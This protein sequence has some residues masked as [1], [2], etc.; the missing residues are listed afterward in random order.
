MAAA[1]PPPVLDQALPTLHDSPSHTDLQPESQGSQPVPFPRQSNADAR[2][3]G[4]PGSGSKQTIESHSAPGSGA[5][6]SPPRSA[7]SPAA[8]IGHTVEGSHPGPGHSSAPLADPRYLNPN[9]ILPP[10]VSHPRRIKDDDL[11]PLPTPD[12]EASSS[13]P[14]LFRRI[15]KRLRPAVGPG[16]QSDAP[17][18]FQI[19]LPTRSRSRSRSRARGDSASGADAPQPQIG[20]QRRPHVRIPVPIPK[21]PAPAP[22]PNSFTSAENRRAALRA[23]GLVPASGSAPRYRDAHGYWMPLSEQE[24]ELDRMFAVVVEEKMPSPDHED[25]E[26]KKF[27]DAW[28]AKYRSESEQ[29]NGSEEQATTAASPSSD[30]R[31]GARAVYEDGSRSALPSATDLAHASAAPAEP[32]RHARRPSADGAMRGRAYSAS[33]TAENRRPVLMPVVD[34]SLPEMPFEDTAAHRLPRARDRRSSDVSERVSRWFQTSLRPRS[35]SASRPASAGADGGRAVRPV[36]APPL[37]RRV[38]R[39]DAVHQGE[40]RET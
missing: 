10:P 6:S 31:H 26:A 29:G 27:R 21:A 23:R 18:S 34:P 13:T 33:A 8:S 15:T 25:T 1:A 20:K 30:A 32:S 19:S 16:E 3:G 9:P 5:L 17:T 14:G 35:A 11:P 12:S 4:A 2:A 39:G 7:A 28:L 24:R 38:G 37:D 36:L 40:R 22:L